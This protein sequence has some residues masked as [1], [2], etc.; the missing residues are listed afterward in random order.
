MHR[1][2]GPAAA[3]PAGPAAAALEL[4]GFQRQTGVFL[5]VCLSDKSSKSHKRFLMEFCKGVGHGSWRTRRS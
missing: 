2:I 4:I 3:G 1:N 5:S